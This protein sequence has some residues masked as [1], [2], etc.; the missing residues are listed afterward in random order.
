MGGLQILMAG[1][2]I[3][4]WF[5]FRNPRPTSEDSNRLSPGGLGSS[6]WLYIQSGAL[7]D[8]ACHLPPGPIRVRYALACG[9]TWGPA[10]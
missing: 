3:V 6:P 8:I 4:T 1:P 9:S 5:A 2:A 10:Q 7:Q